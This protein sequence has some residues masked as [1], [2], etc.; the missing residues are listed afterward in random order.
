MMS[1]RIKAYIKSLCIVL[2]LTTNVL[3]FDV[4]AQPSDGKQLADVGVLKG[5]V[6]TQDGKSIVGAAL[7]VNGQRIRTDN[8]GYFELKLAPGK[9]S[10]YVVYPGFEPQTI[11]NVV[12]KLGETRTL[13]IQLQPAIPTQAVED[14]SPPPSPKRNSAEEERRV[15]DGLAPVNKSRPKKGLRRLRKQRSITSF[16]LQGSG[17]SYA[18]P[19]GRIHTAE[20]FNTESYDKINDN[21]FRDT[22]QK[23]LSTFSIDVDTASY[24]NIRRMLSHGSLPPPDA[25]RIE[26]LINYF[27]YDYPDATTNQPFSVTTEL[28]VAPWNK[29]HQLLHIG[30]QGKKIDNQDIPRRNLVFLLDVSGSMN[31][32][33]KLPLLKRGMK[34][35][36]QQL[37][38]NDQ[39]S[40]V[41]YAGA[42]G[43][44]LPPTSGQNKQ[45]II[46]ALDKLS[47]GGSTNGGQGIELAYKTAQQ[48]WIKGGINRVI[49]ATDGD[50]NVGVSS[51]GALE[52]LIE[53]KR[54]SGIFLT[55]LGFGS[56]N[57]KDSTL[58]QL[59]DKG[60]GNYGYIDR[61]SEAR[62]LLVKEAGATLVTIA[63]D[64]KIQIEFNPKY[65]HQYRLIGYENRMLATEDFN[66]DK[67]DAGDI[68]AGHSVTA[69]YELIAPS[70]A[71]DDASK[72]VDPLKYQST[73]TK[74][75]QAASDELAT[76]KLRYKEPSKSKSK[77]IKKVVSA[78]V[79]DLDKTSDDYRFSASVAGF[80]MLL[81]NSKFKA[82][83]T[84]SLVS[85]LA[86]ASL[87]Q[88]SDNYRKEF[89]EL[90]HRTEQISATRSAK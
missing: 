76:V 19:M 35:L 66:D 22:T 17:S 33:D 2:A 14:A 32:P 4:Q 31:S 90:I 18:A 13:K 8:K 67:K 60:N 6:R 70:E 55:V 42:S 39:L 36:V 20:K 72:A 24:S 9:Y 56:G 82:D 61:L 5:Y 69:I 27:S 41:V 75:S 79:L 80:G 10:I 68:G 3:S 52:R 50:F 53:E 85:S 86:E 47:A 51:R 1:Y 45:A 59:A 44:V 83:T 26:E 88:D 7:F 21:E 81:R 64:V 30:I 78:E 28:S 58:E 16:S 71:K 12:V 43:L 57:L 48:N 15:K 63:K 49:L 77:L 46:D 23:P 38:E 84:Y 37:R 65:V 87:G 62:K 73:R 34:L 89:L 40:I 54:K 74:T 25:V 11:K 29:K